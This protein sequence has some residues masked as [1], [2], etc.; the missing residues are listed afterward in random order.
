MEN[1][2]DG[3]RDDNETIGGNCRVGFDIKREKLMGRSC[4]NNGTLTFRVEMR[5]SAKEYPIC[6]S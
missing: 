4:L 5:L 3:G 2:I 1:R 6:I